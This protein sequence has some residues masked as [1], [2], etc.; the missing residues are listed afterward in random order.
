MDAD[1][2][3][4]IRASGW[5]QGAIFPRSLALYASEHGEPSFEL[6]TNDLIIVISQTCDVVYRNF[7][8]EPFVEFILAS[9]T[10]SQGDFRWGKSPRR[11]HLELEGLGSFEVNAH[12]KSRLPRKILLKY[13]P[14]GTLA[15]K[16]L[17][18]FVRWIALRYA[19]S[20][21]PDTFNDR[22]A[23]V[24]DEIKKS[25]RKNGSDITGIYL[26]VQDEELPS[27]K[28]YQIH[29]KAVMEPDSFNDLLKRKKAQQAIADMI[30]LLAS[31]EGVKFLKK[32]IQ[33]VSE[34]KLSLDEIRNTKRWDSD[35]LSFREDKEEDIPIV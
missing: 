30:A 3:S 20:A 14:N 32:E 8:A 5:Q 11:Y 24:R 18:Q 15:G 9:P 31:C 16:Q 29:G 6:K 34:K 27:K 1:D 26:Y 7:S 13:S 21:F 25:L 35:S 22:V 33:V 2:A 28:T 19:R 4:A 17:D 10:L 23:P 12:N